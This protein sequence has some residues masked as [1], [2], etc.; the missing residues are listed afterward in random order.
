MEPTS[1]SYATLPRMQHDTCCRIFV[2]GISL[3]LFIFILVY[4][5]MIMP[6][7]TFANIYHNVLKYVLKVTQGTGTIA[8]M[9]GLRST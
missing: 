4:K 5:P 1:G 7:S 3:L 6:A 9:A 8:N 2:L